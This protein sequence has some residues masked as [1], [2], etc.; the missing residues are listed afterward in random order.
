MTCWKCGGCGVIVDLENKTMRDCDCY[1]VRAAG[2]TVPPYDD[3]EVAA[4]LI[5]KL[6][7][8]LV[9]Q[10]NM[11]ALVDDAAKHFGVPRDRI[12]QAARD[13]YWLGLVDTV[14]G[15]RFVFADGE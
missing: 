8:W 3:I 2:V 9:K 10:P 5:D 14:D 1:V 6:Q 4:T 12:E 7:S 15:D 11:S 13:G